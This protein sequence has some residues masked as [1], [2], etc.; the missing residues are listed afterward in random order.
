MSASTVSALYT[1]VQLDPDVPAPGRASLADLTILAPRWLGR[2]L[3]EAIAAQDLAGAARILAS[4]EA[5]IVAVHLAPICP[6][7][8][9]LLL[10]LHCSVLDDAGVDTD[11]LAAITT[12][13]HDPTVPT[14]TP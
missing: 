8:K 9:D 12:T 7:V 2:P 1:G 5:R 10:R 13:L 6:V 14:R 4:L 11:D 3:D